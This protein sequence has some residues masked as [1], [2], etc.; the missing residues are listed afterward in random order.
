MFIV[1]CGR[2]V[3]MRVLSIQ[4]V[5]AKFRG[6]VIYIPMT[7]PLVRSPYLYFL[8][9]LQ[10]SHFPWEKGKY[11]FQHFSFTF[12]VPRLSTDTTFCK[13]AMTAVCLH[14]KICLPF[15]ADSSDLRG[16]YMFTRKAIATYG[17]L[18]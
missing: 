17:N 4:K 15:P 18:T 13:V 16:I 14:G 12:F 11:T 3:E 7:L 6:T 8:W 1:L 2:G 9:S 5:V 10:I